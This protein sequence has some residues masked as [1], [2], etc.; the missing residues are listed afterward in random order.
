LARN[1]TD[2]RLEI[3]QENADKS[4]GRF[5]EAELTIRAG[6]LCAGLAFGGTLFGGAVSGTAAAP[7]N[8]E[9]T[10]IVKKKLTRRR[11]TA[12]LP[13]YQRGPAVE[14]AP[15]E[16]EDPLSYE[17]SR[18]VVYLEGRQTASPV[19]AVLEQENRR[20]GQDTVVIPAGSK[21]SFPNQDPIFHN[22][23]SLSK[24][25]IFDLG[26]Y[27][28]GE[29]RTVTFNEPGIVF[30]NCHLHANMA[31]AIVV[32]PN[33]W[34]ARA[35][36]D[37]HFTLRDVPP[38]SYTAV[39]WHKA[40]GFLRKQIEVVAGRGASLEFLIPL[41]DAAPARETDALKLQTRR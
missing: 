5:G 36:R 28:K 23:F 12:S 29:T 8:I 1:K 26:N 41:D 39:A 33:K 15:D 32:T 35:D 7:G 20:F 18:V 31:A 14:L 11:V 30:V 2:V 13:L 24:T 6:V 17:R 38:G 40:A 10:I 3:G 25:K 9:G 4:V 19:T 34:Y 16:P 22:V 37:G 27:S 21:V